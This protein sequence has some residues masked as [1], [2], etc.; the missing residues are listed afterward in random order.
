MAKCDARFQTGGDRQALYVQRVE[1]RCGG[2]P[3]DDYQTLVMAKVAELL[4]TIGE[5]VQQNFADARPFIFWREMQCQQHVF[6][7]VMGATQRDAAP[8]LFD[9]F[10][11]GS[12]ALVHIQWNAQQP[13]LQSALD[14]PLHGA[15][16][17]AGKT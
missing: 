8:Y 1:D 2:F 13:R 5:N 14:L 9:F 16:I 7:L 15:I 3:T 12:K 10:F 17:G 11:I 6:P 4:C